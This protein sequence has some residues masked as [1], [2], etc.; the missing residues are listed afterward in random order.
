MYR[1]EDRG[2][3]WREVPYPFMSLPANAFPVG[4][5][6]TS[7]AEPGA[8]YLVRYSRLFRGVPSSFPDPVVVE[9]Q[10]EGTRYW[11]TSLDGEALSQDY[12]QQPGDVHRTGLRWGAWRADDAPAGAVGSCRFWPTPRIGRTRVL[13]QQGFE[14]DN[15]K[16]DPGWILEGEDEFFTMLP[17]NNVCP[18]GTVAVYRFNNLEADF[19]HRWVADPV[20]IADMRARGWYD[21]GVRFCARPLGSNE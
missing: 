3:S 14:C 11:L 21:E 5:V 4:T 20:A 9:Y 18:A 19:N 15:L 10:Y 16:R 17:A 8:V 1:S 7:P 2:D 6:V 12:R 13:V